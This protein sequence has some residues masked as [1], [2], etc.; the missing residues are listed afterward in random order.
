MLDRDPTGVRIF[1]PGCRKLS[2]GARKLGPGQ[3]RRPTLRISLCDMPQI[4]AKRSQDEMVLR[5]REPPTRALY[6]QL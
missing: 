2:G 1:G 3:E 6:L 4:A 5:A